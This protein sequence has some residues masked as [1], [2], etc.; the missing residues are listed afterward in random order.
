MNKPVKLKEV[1]ESKIKNNV[2]YKLEFLKINWVD[3]VGKN[4]AKKSFPL[5]V[6]EDVLI[7]GV[8]SSIWSQQMLFLK[9]QIIKNSNLKLNG[10]YIKNIRFKVSKYEKTINYIE[11]KQKVKREKIDFNN[12]SIQPFEIKQLKKAIEF[13]KDDDIKRHIYKVSVLNKK[14]EKYLLENGYKKC[15]KCGE[16]FVGEGKICILCKNDIQKENRRRIYNKIKNNLLI[17]YT[18]MKYEEKYLTKIEFEDIKNRV[19]DG[20]Y[21]EILINIKELKY[22]KARDLLEKYFILDSGTDNKRVIFEKIDM[23]F[24]SFT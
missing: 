9:N 14:R 20:I 16:L 1:I 5:F 6:K 24:Q 11:K 7:I 23:F 18:E 15:E 13:I 4:L 10:E 2:F 21:R 3:I 8:T 22:K 12:I 19:K 17:T